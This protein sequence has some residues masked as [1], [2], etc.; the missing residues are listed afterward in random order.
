VGS[1]RLGCHRG[2]CDASCTKVDKSLPLRIASHLIDDVSRILV[3]MNDLSFLCLAG[4]TEGVHEQV[5][6]FGEV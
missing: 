5:L 1:G 6:A 2:C 3:A 4:K